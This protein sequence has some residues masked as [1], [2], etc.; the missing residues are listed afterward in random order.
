M[1]EQTQYKKAGVN[2]EAGEKLVDWL[3]DS[4]SQTTSTTLN[5]LQNHLISGIGGFASIFKIPPGYQKPCLVSCTDGVGSKLLLG[6][7]A[8]QLQG[9]GQ[10]LVAMCLN[11]LIVQGASPLFFLDYFSTSHLDLQTAKEFLLGIQTACK[12]GKCLLVGGETAEMPG[13][14]SKNH[15]DCAGFAVGVVEE[16]QIIVGESVQKGDCVL[17]IESSGF[18]SNGYSLLR[19]VFKP[20][21][22]KYLK[23]LLIP[24]RLY[25][26]PICNLL[27]QKVEI[28]A[29]AHITGGGM[30]NISRV[31]NKEVS[32]TI[33][34]WVWP[35]IY[36]EIQER[37][38]MTATEMLKTFNC[39]IGYI[40]I[41]PPISVTAVQKEFDLYGWHIQH[42]GTLEPNRTGN[43]PLHYKLT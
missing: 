43:P 24:T 1:K 32:F 22:E 11:D 29:M 9:L 27:E 41:V 37:T 13:F 2:I 16:D 15:F 19:K 17:G 5:K 40:L 31:L 8:G 30:N 26:K 35:P 33:D 3:K 36:K 34:Q 7:Q 38:G 14:Y 21:L 23:Q 6:I 25:V 4:S 12:E 10:D 39:G 42:L 18:H 20:D 28:H